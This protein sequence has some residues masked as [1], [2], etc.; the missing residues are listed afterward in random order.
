MRPKHRPQRSCVVCREKKDKRELTRLV[1]T[2]GR[3][4]VDMS[5][6][7]KRRGAYM[8]DKSVCW[9]QATTPTQLSRALRQELSDGDRDYL[10]QMTPS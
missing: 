4:Q 8:C 1:M 5:G 7:M 2:D 3:L 9:A 6:K 10:R